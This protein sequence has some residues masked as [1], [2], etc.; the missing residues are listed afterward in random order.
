MTKLAK[1]VL[2]Q[3]KNVDIGRKMLY[4]VSMKKDIKNDMKKEGD[5]YE[6]IGGRAYS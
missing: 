4:N 6:T 3:K 2:L 5:C 1:N